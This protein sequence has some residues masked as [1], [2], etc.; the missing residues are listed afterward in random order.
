MLSIK[1]V[2]GL[3]QIDIDLVEPALIVPGQVLV[4]LGLICGGPGTPFQKSAM[5]AI[6]ELD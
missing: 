1:S 5:E 2:I 3:L 6:I 4:E